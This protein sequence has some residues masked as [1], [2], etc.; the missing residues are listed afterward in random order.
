M[1][2]T[3]EDEC[4]GC[5]PEM[6][7][8]GSACPYRNVPHWICDECEAEV[9]EG[10]LWNVNGKEICEDCLKEMY[11]RVK[12]EDHDDSEDV[13]DRADYEYDRWKDREDN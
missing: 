3:V 4:V 9:D 10:E 13:Y 7:C 2:I 11:P 1:A 8:L 6:G 12:Y 5:P